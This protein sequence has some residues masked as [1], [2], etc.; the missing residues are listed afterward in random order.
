MRSRQDPF[1]KELALYAA[2]LF[3]M[4]VLIRLAVPRLA[5]MLPDWLDMTITLAFVSV[6]TL[7]IVGILLLFL[8]GRFEESDKTIGAK[9]GLAVWSLVPLSFLTVMIVAILDAVFGTNLQGLLPAPSKET[10][11]FISAG[12]GVIVLLV[13]MLYFWIV[14][15]A[16]DSSWS[17]R[18]MSLKVF[19]IWVGFGCVLLVMSGLTDGFVESMF[20]PDFKDDLVNISEGSAT[21]IAIAGAALLATCVSLWPR[22][23]RR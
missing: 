5:S 6:F 8:W 9:L 4:F 16:D 3:V 10:Q 19:V 23:G 15:T 7:A 22:G 20:G 2:G 18:F 17:E 13:S 1:D 21:K 12:A 11:R 14:A